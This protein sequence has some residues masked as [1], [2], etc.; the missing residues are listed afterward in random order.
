MLVNRGADAVSFWIEDFNLETGTKLDEEQPGPMAWVRMI[1]GN[2]RLVVTV[3]DD[4]GFDG[5][6]R[7]SATVNVAAPTRDIDVMTIQRSPFTDEV[8]TTLYQHAGQ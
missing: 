3:R 8:D 5:R 6:D 7:G 4:L 1:P 2:G